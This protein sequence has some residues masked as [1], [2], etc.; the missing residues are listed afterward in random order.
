MD[1]RDKDERAQNNG[2]EC[3]F[4]MY[5]SNNDETTFGLSKRE[6]FAGLAMQAIIQNGKYSEIEIPIC[7]VNFADELLQALEYKKP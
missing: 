4:A 5:D 2:S 6:Y 7:A 3:A 1:K